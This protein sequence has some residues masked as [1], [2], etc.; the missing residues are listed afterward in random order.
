METIHWK[1]CKK[2]LR[3]NLGCM[4]NSNL[5]KLTAS[6]I[7]DTPYKCTENRKYQN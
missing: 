6:Q 4:F 5:N 7:E 1:I 2:I 3:E